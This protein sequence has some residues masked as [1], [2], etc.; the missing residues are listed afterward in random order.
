VNPWADRSSFELRA[1]D[2]SLNKAPDDANP[3]TAY[4]RQIA[5][6]ATAGA[7]SKQI[8]RRIILLLRT[9]GTHVYRVFRK[10]G[11]ARREEP[12]KA[13]HQNDSTID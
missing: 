1:T 3:L 5:E 6:L 2:A 7:T 9:V 4:E 13:L 12:N 11:I 8:A 10:L